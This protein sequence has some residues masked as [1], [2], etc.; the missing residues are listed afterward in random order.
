MPCDRRHRIAWDKWNRPSP[1]KA[2]ADSCLTYRHAS[3]PRSGPPHP[4]AGAESPLRIPPCQNVQPQRGGAAVPRSTR[5]STKAFLHSR[6]PAVNAASCHRDR[7]STA[8][9]P[10][11]PSWSKLGVR[12]INR[13]ILAMKSLSGNVAL[14]LQLRHSWRSEDVGIR[15]NMP[16]SESEWQNHVARLANH[17]REFRIGFRLRAVEQNIE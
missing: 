4:R 6:P 17:T 13:P 8:S 1:T 3:A 5:P 14:H 12:L 11:Q 10:T 16:R 7:A 15:L 9:R 2:R